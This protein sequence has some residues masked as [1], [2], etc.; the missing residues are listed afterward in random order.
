MRTR[1][2]AASRDAPQVLAL[3]VGA[4]IRAIKRR[5][6]SARARTPQRCLYQ[7]YRLGPSR[8]GVYILQLLLFSAGCFT[9]CNSS[10]GSGSGSDSGSQIK[11]CGMFHLHRVGHQSSCAPQFASRLCRTNRFVRNATRAHAHPY[12]RAALESASRSSWPAR[13]QRVF[14]CLFVC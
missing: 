5:R 8:C 11:R 9:S 10:G 6:V 2:P 13:G 12:T 1:P 3:F 4:H 7:L 14:V